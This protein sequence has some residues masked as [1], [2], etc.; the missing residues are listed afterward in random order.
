MPGSKQSEVESRTR[1][2]VA[3]YEVRVPGISIFPRHT[4]I[5]APLSPSED[6]YLPKQS[7]INSTPHPKSAASQFARPRQ[8]QPT[9]VPGVV[10]VRAPAKQ[11]LSISR[12]A[13]FAA[14]P[15][16][17]STR[18]PSDGRGDSW[19]GIHCPPPPTLCDWALC[20]LLSRS[21]S[22]GRI[23]RAQ[24]V[25]QRG[26]GTLHAD[27]RGGGG[28]VR[29][30]WQANGVY[31][32]YITEL[33]VEGLLPSEPCQRAVWKSE[34]VCVYETCRLYMLEI[35]GHELE[36]GCVV[37]RVVLEGCCFLYPESY[38]N[39]IKSRI[40]S[41]H[42][43]QCQIPASNPNKSQQIPSISNAHARIAAWGPVLPSDIAV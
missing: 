34:C 15:F 37:S 1:C 40:K 35:N 36:H 42:Q 14:P 39:G 33:Q 41:Q 10:V 5:T 21:A 2:R 43:I 32:A 38:P 8:Q 11:V 20:A 3:G 31:V 9:R 17:Q 24:P 29:G 12:G 22:H 18:A 4:R 30:W 7:S 13:S 16:P 6:T 25:S 27:S 26:G 19:T 23:T 28:E